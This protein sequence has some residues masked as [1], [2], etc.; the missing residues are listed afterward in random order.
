MSFLHFLIRI[1]I[2]GFFAGLWLA[3]G[4]YLYLSPNLPDVETLRDVKLQTPMRVYTREGDLIGQFGEQK[5]SPL[6]FEDIP[7]QFVKALLAAEDDSFFEHR[8]IDV[9]G[10]ARAVS[11]LVLTGQKGS[12]GSTLTMQV[13]RN[14]FLSLERTFMRKFNEILLAIEIERAL[15]K[16]EIFELYFNR[17]FL[18]HRAYGFEAA[19]QV[20]YGKGMDQLSLAQHAMLAGIPKAPSR[21]NPV[22]GPEA[23][24]DRRNWIA[25]RMLTLGYITPEQHAE[26]L[27]APVL[28]ELHGAK[29]SFAAH[30]A[31]EMA[32]QR[33]LNRY[34]M[35]AYNDG[36]HVYTTI[37]TELQQVARE[38]LIEGLF[39]YDGRH[40]YR[41]PEQRWPLTDDPDTD[42]LAYWGDKLRKIPEVAGQT[43]AVVTEVLE[44][45]VVVL[46]KDGSASELLWENGMAEVRPYV[47]ENS[48]ESS[49]ETPQ[50]LF[51]PGDLIRLNSNEQGRWQLSQIPAAQSALVSLN[52][53]NGAIVSIVGGMGF[54]LSKFNRATQAMRQPGSNFKPFLYS[55]AL[56]EGFTAA[57]IINDAPVVMADSSLEDVW[58]P[59]NDGGVFHGPTRLRW[60]LTKSRNLVSIR[61]LQQLGAR[62][63]ITA[64]ERYGFDTADFSPDLSLALGTHAMSPLEVA[65]GYAMLANGGYRVEPYLIS[66]IDDISGEQ[67]YEAKP[68][69]VC[70][71]CDD[72]PAPAD[73]GELSM[74]EI[75][76]AQSKEKAELPAAPRVMEERINYIMNSVLQDVITRGTGRRA[77][78]LERGDLA[79]KTGTTNGPMDAWF[80]GY[81]RDVVTT[82]WVGF[83]NYTPLGRREF[84][85]TA[86]LPIWI[87]YMREALKNSP[88]EKRV[89]PTGVVNVRIDP[90]TGMLAGS[91]QKNVVYEYFREEYVPQQGPDGEEAGSVGQGT[92]D[93]VR[94][95]F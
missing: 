43:P 33:M 93:L 28:A 17:V 15:D 34:G 27:T 90:D 76:A 44:D 18:G 14:Y 45:R 54:E 83:D 7:D 16:E 41:G 38:A 69:T 92:D 73:A 91:R 72:R 49:P 46:L 94:D 2:L 58:R 40:G 60:A 1:S 70:R 57:S 32:R 5:R 68:L 87:N 12:G 88:D 25:G 6:V 61:L 23:G 75:L 62:K 95:I 37:S 71:D 80:S 4:V 79:G 86:A 35:S 36:Y 47:T 13:A 74:E 11:E 77:L 55:A 10:L 26:V 52:P 20:Y 24:K 56:E 63:L 64:A 78:V 39:T 67:V 31:A 82:T 48:R 22:S 30:Y 50:E 9:M 65:T 53:D 85:G 21:N 84:G 3:A 89:L 59:E 81:N 8:G 66:R 51:T 29:I 42:S 19:S